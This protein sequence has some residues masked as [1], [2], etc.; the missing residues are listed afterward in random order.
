MLKVEKI[1][2]LHG[3]LPWGFGKTN[4]YNIPTYKDFRMSKR[5]G[6]KDCKKEKGKEGVRGRETERSR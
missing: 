3:T 6:E 4:K 5:D 1:R 2:V